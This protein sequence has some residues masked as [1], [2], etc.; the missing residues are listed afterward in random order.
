[1]NP[2]VF[3]FVITKTDHYIFIFFMASG[4]LHSYTETA[5]KATAEGFFARQWALEHLVGKKS[6]QIV[7]ILVA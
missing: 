1:M 7:A 5:G 6:A 4:Y 2:L 3:S